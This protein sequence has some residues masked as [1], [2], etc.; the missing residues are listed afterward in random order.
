MEDLI[1]DMASKS[2]MEPPE[3]VVVV[4]PESRQFREGLWVPPLNYTG[5]IGSI[6]DALSVINGTLQREPYNQQFKFMKKEIEQAVELFPT[7]V[8]EYDLLK[9]KLDP[10]PEQ[11]VE[12]TIRADML[13]KVKI[14][15]YHQNRVEGLISIIG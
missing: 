14:I 1:A 4:T 15:K 2:E 7:L 8:E 10:L 5:R 12:D 6:D 13:E 11:D 3:E 9:A